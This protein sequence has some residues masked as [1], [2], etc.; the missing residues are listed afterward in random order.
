[1]IDMDWR[2][3]A[4]CQYEDPELFFP[5]SLTKVAEAKAVCAGCPVRAACLAYAFTTGQDAG[6]WGGMTEHERRRELRRRFRARTRGDTRPA[7]APRPR[8]DAGAPHEQ[9]ERGEQRGA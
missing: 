5:L 1:V 8:S 7:P 2:H 4:D 9:R 6:I 3:H